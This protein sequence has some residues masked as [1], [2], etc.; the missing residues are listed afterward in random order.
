MAEKLTAFYFRRSNSL[1][2][3]ACERVEMV[4]ERGKRSSYSVD[5][6]TDMNQY[7]DLCID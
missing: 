4:G 3:Y 7:V 1:N 2:L 6:A 5:R